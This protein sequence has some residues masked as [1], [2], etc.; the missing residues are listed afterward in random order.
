MSKRG[1]NRI[2]KKPEKAEKTPFFYKKRL[3]IILV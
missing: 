3:K 2:N 1:A